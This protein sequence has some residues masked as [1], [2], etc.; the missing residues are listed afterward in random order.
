MNNIPAKV[1]YIVSAE[2]GVIVGLAVVM[3]YTLRAA[4]AIHVA[5]RWSDFNRLSGG[6]S[7]GRS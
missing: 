3:F 5:G 7:I 6:K 2:A 1:V 4:H